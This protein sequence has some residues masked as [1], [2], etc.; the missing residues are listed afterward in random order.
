MTDFRALLQNLI[1]WDG[2][3]G[4][5]GYHA[6]KLYDARQAALD[7]LAEPHAMGWQPMVGSDPVGYVGKIAL[8]LVR[9]GTASSCLLHGS[10]DGI[11]E[12]VP[13]YQVSPQVGIFERRYRALCDWYLRGGERREI[14]EYGHIELTTQAHID[15]WADSIPTLGQAAPHTENVAAKGCDWE[16]KK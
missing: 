2:G 13:L 8:N 5:K 6:F 3:E 11:G 14:H 10:S 15:A 16:E 9:E 1:E 7:A 4:S 12:A